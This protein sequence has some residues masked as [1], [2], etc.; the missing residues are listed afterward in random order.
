MKKLAAIIKNIKN[1]TGLDINAFPEDNIQSISDSDKSAFLPD[2]TDFTETYCSERLKRT[3]FKFRYSGTNYI[4]SIDGISKASENYAFLIVSL[5]ENYR[6]ETEG[7]SDN[8]II[9]RT[10]LGE[11]SPRAFEL[12]CENKNIDG[13][14]CFCLAISCEKQKSAVL[15]DYFA[16]KNKN[17][18]NLIAE[19]DS[20]TVAFVKI[21][22]RN[23]EKPSP[24]NFAMKIHD[25]I[26]KNT[27]IK[28]VIGV[29][30]Y[31]DSL[32]KISMSYNEATLALKSNDFLNRD[33][34]VRFYRDFTVVRLLSELPKNKLDEVFQNLLNED[35]RNIFDDE[36]MVLT[37]RV[38]MENDLNISEASRE[39]FM[40]RNTLTYRLDKIEKATNL[41]VR[42]FSDA[43]TFCVLSL[44]KTI[45]E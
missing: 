42:K 7:V 9:K 13:E 34:K 27:G 8:E 20:Q 5:I 4:G 17:P 25:E 41:D 10:V 15:P 12:F 32:P 1:R 35:G 39:L 14:E 44:I 45:S 16:A 19:I 2:K 18:Y 24:K 21:L 29:G 28:T 31:K 43:V 37:A 33:A 36:E 3:F 38:L 22:Q 23:E 30:C 6:D 40:H 11:M 26:L